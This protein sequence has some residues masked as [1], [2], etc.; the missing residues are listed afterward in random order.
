MSPKASP[1]SSTPAQLL[2]GKELENGW[3]VE[4]MV[5]RTAN[6]T[7][8]QFS[9]SYIVRSSSGQTAFL[10]AMDYQLA[11]EAH[12]PAKV[13]QFMTAAYNF[14]R[15]MLAIC[16]SKGLTRIVRILD[17]G[18]VYAEDG[19]PSSVVQ[20]LI[21][22]LATGDIRSVASFGDAADHAWILRTI[23]Q[24][25]AALQQLHGAEIAHQDIKPSNVLTFFDQPSKLADLGRSYHLHTTSPHDELTCAGDNTYA[26]PELLYG[27]VHTDWRTRRIAADLY[28]LGSL[29]VYLFTGVSTTHL[30]LKRAGAKH[31]YKSGISYS[32]VLPYL[33]HAF[34]QV[35]RELPRSV[36]SY[37]ASEIVQS[38]AQLCNLEPLKRG[39]PKDTANKRMRFSMQRYVSLFDRLARSAEFTLQRMAG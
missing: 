21:F 25:T 6:A 11:L 1:S 14:E 15:D 32:E 7:G 38:V 27:D 4:Q 30:L 29:I 31:H 10:K 2:I 36:P 20:Y 13:L 24:A 9:T 34:A 5:D 12:D 19:N 33:Q 16:R 26:P 3:Y 17:D 8:A 28:L 39:H 22:E 35:L 37:V 23:H 18:T